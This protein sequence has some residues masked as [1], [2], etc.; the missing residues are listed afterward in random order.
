MVSVA[1]PLSVQCQK[2]LQ[3]HDVHSTNVVTTTYVTMPI[4]TSETE[5][6]YERL[7]SV[8]YRKCGEKDVPL[9]ALKLV[10]CVTCELARCSGSK[11]F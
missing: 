7:A 8:S 9:H 1:I 11:V 2:L 6:T 4:I 10:A 3:Q 5:Q